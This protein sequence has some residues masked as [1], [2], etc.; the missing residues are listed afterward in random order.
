[1]SESLTPR[2]NDLSRPF[3]DAAAEDRLSLPYCVETGRAF[4]PPA[5]TSPFRTAGAVEWRE[6]EAVG[7]V[8]SIVVYRRAFQSALAAHLP[9]GIALV[10]VAR[11]VRLLVHLEDP[12]A[13]PKPGTRVSLCFRRL[14]WS[15]MPVLA[16]A[17]QE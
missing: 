14:E 8:S 12:D 4:W 7:I 17:P 15:E 5:P 2:V 3:W 13:A 6:A 11:G 1:M 16:I 10:Q 9:Y